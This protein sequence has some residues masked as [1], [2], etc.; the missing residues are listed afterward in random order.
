MKD[1]FSH[2]K[3]HK[4]FAKRGGLQWWAIRALGYFLSMIASTDVST[5]KATPDLYFTG[6]NTHS[7]ILDNSWRIGTKKYLCRNIA[8]TGQAYFFL[9]HLSLEL[10][11]CNETFFLIVLDLKILFETKDIDCVWLV[12]LMKLQNVQEPKGHYWPIIHQ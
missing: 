3:R 7:S 9:A 4:V 2:V 12:C 8:V 6:T 10:I 1:F 11:R 5:A